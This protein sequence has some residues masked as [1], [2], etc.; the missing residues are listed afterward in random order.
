VR[1]AKVVV[2]ARSSVIL[3]VLFELS[4]AVVRSQV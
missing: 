3:P 4:I 2:L 1:D